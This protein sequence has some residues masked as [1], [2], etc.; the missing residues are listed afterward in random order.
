VMLAT[1]SRE[2]ADIPTKDHQPG[3]PRRERNS[4]WR[5]LVELLRREGSSYE[6]AF[7]TTTRI[8]E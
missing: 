5:P 3:F 2:F 4:T 6:I 1:G 8:E 7:S